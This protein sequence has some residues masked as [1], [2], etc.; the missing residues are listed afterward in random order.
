M[1]ADWKP[2]TEPPRVSEIHS[3]IAVL[4]KFKTRLPEVL[5]YWDDGSWTDT[6]EYPLDELPDKWAYLPD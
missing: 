6:D 1:K 5:L 2:A 3:R 4:C